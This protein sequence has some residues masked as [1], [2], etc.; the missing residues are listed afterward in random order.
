MKIK[1]MKSNRL[2]RR[3]AAIAMAAIILTAISFAGCQPTESDPIQNKDS[4]SVGTWVDTQKM[5]EK[6][7]KYHP[8]AY[9]VD[10]IS[11]DAAKVEAV[12]EAYNLS[13]T[14]STIDELNNDNLE[15]C[16]ASYSVKFPKDFPQSVFGITDVTV[17]FEIVSS[18]GGTIQVGDTIY[19]NLGDT[20]EIGDIPQGYD[21]HAGDTY[22][23]QIVFVMVKGY[24][25]YLIHEIKEGSGDE[26]ETY[27][28]GE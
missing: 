2:R 24:S 12:I 6:D 17:P 14:G 4:V 16:L 21:F 27:I 1:N 8:V 18:T 9:R 20:W 13:G 28:K 22:H 3:W 7:S 19:Q 23:G 25:D 5:A 11:R 26:E 15:F 10:S